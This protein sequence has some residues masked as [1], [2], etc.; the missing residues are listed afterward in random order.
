MNRSLERPRNKWE[1][2]SKLDLR[3]IGYEVV[4]QIQLA[5]HNE[6][7]CFIVGSEYPDQLNDCQHLKK[8][9]APWSHL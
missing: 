4:K 9:P 7:S 2:N 1:N 5:Y 6:S 3:E 8:D